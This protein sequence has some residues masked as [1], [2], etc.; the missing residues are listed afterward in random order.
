MFR[1]YFVITLRNLKKHKG[2][3]F[4]NIAGLAIGMACCILIL[5][6]VTDEVSYDRFHEQGDRIYRVNSISSIG[7]TSR[8]YA[9]TPPALATA[10]T[11]TIP[12]I[13]TSVRFFDTFELEARLEG[14]PIRIPEV[15]FVDDTIFDIFTFPFVAGDP[16]NAFADPDSI[17]ITADTAARLFGDEEALGKVITLPPDRSLRISG[18]VQEVPK[19][20]H[21]QFK[22]LIPSTWLRDREGRP[23]PVLT[24]DYFCEVYAYIVLRDN[25]NMADLD[26]KIASTVESRWGEMYKQRGTS[27]VYPL[28]HLHDI[29]LHSEYEYELGTPGDIDNVIL[30]T[31]IAL[32]VLM[33]AC[34]NF[35]N[36]STARSAGRARE[37]GIRKVF[38]SQKFQLVRQFLSESVAVSLISLFLGISIVLSILPL[39][40]NL[41]GKQF[42]YAQFLKLPVLLGLLGIVILTGLIAGSFPAFILS[43]FNPVMVLKGRLSSASKNSALRKILVVVQ[44]S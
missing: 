29:H 26:Q 44:F 5:L 33:I 38:G 2:Y 35:I 41:S 32:L 36:L 16:E 23:S 1:N 20:S 19:N 24:A 11:E 3:S 37:V 13:E 12:E 30:F 42:G 43:A 15:W 7:A 18:V 31:G 10:L 9:H 8:H 34:F 25:T 39:F 21:F 22:G 4:I 40:N 17:V 14:E 28:I 6:Y 27:R